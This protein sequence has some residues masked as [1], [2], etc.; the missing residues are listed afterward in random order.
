MLYCLYQKGWQRDDF[1]KITYRK[2]LSFAIGVAVMLIIL[3][4]LYW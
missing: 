4:A 3:A 2:P 1:R